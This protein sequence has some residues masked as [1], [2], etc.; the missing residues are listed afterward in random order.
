MA[1]SAVLMIEPKNFISNPQTVGDNFFQATHLAIPA[2]EL[3]KKVSEEFYSL[4]N[5]LEECGI[6][7]HVFHQSDNLETPDA[8]YP[9]NWFSTHR[10]DTLI[11]YPM[12]ALNRRIERRK[13]IV[14]ELKKTYTVHI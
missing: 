5:R 13:N 11:T 1:A 2:E 9:N 10:N 7:V 4:K 3:N 6:E 14:Q 8:I 12:L